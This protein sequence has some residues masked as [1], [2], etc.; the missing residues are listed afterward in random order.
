[1]I[2]LLII[3]ILIVLLIWYY[4]VS[5]IKSLYS[6][7]VPYVWSFNRQLKI[8]KNLNLKKWAK[9]V[10]LWCGDGKALRFFEKEFWLKW[11]W[12]D[13]NSFAINYWKLINKIQK[14]NIKLIKSNFIWKNISWYDY[15]YLYLFPEF[16]EKIEDWIFESKDK[17]SIII[18][19]SFKFKR[20]KPFEIIWKKI[21]LYK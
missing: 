13:I 4:Y 9:I 11:T 15:I 19:N 8:L 14:N 12:Y 3:L 2:I 5:F 18:S 17:N 21:Y 20:H 1:M 6:T 7:K 16:M 10:D